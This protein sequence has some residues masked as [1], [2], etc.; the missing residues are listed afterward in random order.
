MT[1]IVQKE[2]FFCC[3]SVDACYYPISCNF[4]FHPNEGKLVAVFIVKLIEGLALFNVAASYPRIPA[5]PRL[6]I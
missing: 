6:N 2:A 3:F 5:S 1:L 4:N